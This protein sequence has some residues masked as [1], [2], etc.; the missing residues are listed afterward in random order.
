[1]PWLTRTVVESY[2][3]QV[4]A[5]VSALIDR[6]IEKGRFDVVSD[7]GGP[8]SAMVVALLLG[9]DPGDAERIA[10]PFRAYQAV[11]RSS[12]DFRRVI[13]E[14]MW[15]AGLLRETASNAARIPAPMRSAAWRSRGST[16]SWC[17][18]TTASGSCRP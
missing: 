12:P 9:L 5:Y 17:R 2:A 10:W 11:D 3:A 4:R 13:D 15:L 6:G 18:S 8:L 1:L 16:V 14:M 7:L